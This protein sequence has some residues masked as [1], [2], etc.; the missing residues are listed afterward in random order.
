M[1]EISI[2]SEQLSFYKL[3]A[4]KNYSIEIPIIQRDFAQGRDSAERIRNDFLD[5]LYA[6]LDDGIP[7]RDLDFIYGDL[8]SQ[9]NLIPLDGQQRLTTLFLLHWYLAL[10]EAQYESFRKVVFTEKTSKFLYKTR[11]SSEDFCNALLENGLDLNN[12]LVSDENQQ[13]AVSKTIKDSPWYFLFWEKD[14]TVQSMLRML[15]SIHEKFS[16]SNGFYDKLVDSG[17]PVITFRFLP[18]KDYGFTDDLYIKMNSRGKPLTNFENFKARF[19]QH[20]TDKQF[21]SNKYK[22]IFNG[23]ETDANPNTYFSH[24]ID[25]KWAKLFWHFKIKREKKVDDEIVVDFE[26]DSLMM[27]FIA[28]LGINHAALTKS[29]IR[30]LIDSQ[31]ELP[32]SFYSELDSDFV[33]TLIKILDILSSDHRLK[34]F[35]GKNHYYNELASFKN[36]IN[37]NFSDAAY[38]ERIQFYAYYSYLIY[39]EGNDTGLFNW[40]RVITNLSTNTMPYN[41]DTEFINSI[42]NIKAILPNSNKILQ[43]L[44]SEDARNLRGFNQTQIKEEKIKAHLITKNEEWNECIL[45]Y[46]KHGYFKGQLTFALSFAGIEAYFDDNN[47]CNWS[48]EDNAVYFNKFNSYILKVFSL[49]SNTGVVNDAMRNHRLHRAILSKGNYLILAKSNLSFLN[50][51]HRDVSWKRFLQGEGERKDKRKYLKEVLDDPLFDEKNLEVLEQI[52]KN[53][54]SSIEAWR[55][56]FI[57]FPVVFNHLGA[58]KFIRLNNLDTVYILKGE[59]RS[60]EH[61]ELFSLCKYYEL[62]EDIFFK[63]PNPFKLFGYYYPNGDYSP[64]FYLRYWKFGRH[65]FFLKGSSSTANKIMLMLYD[66]NRNDCSSELIDTF[67]AFGFSST[68]NIYFFLTVNENEVR[69]TLVSFCKKMENL[70]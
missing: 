47:S 48:E 55:T 53:Y 4:E 29:E 33:Y 26:I 3:F 60:G 65:E 37:K 21:H 8:D 70:V 24:R 54:K 15:D 22:L 58:M 10:K 57:E 12:L 36:I 17:N 63:N 49:F 1:N 7:L 40:M 67:K 23:E 2:K 30:E 64:S 45:K 44:K 68:E 46:E 14:P 16:T 39:N 19:E 31:N 25:T 66:E 6:Y 61:A 42:R 50:D 56:K 51:S 52:A 5:A 20:L 11:T 9:N 69:D 34:T 18:L 28:T 62:K 41:N 32:F 43:Y 35:L 59:R 27:N 13:N 38:W